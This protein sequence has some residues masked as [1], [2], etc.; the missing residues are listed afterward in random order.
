MSCGNLLEPADT[1]LVYMTQRVDSVRLRLV[2]RDSHVV[3]VPPE[4]ALVVLE[5]CSDLGEQGANVG[6]LVATLLVSV[7]DRLVGLGG[8][9]RETVEGEDEL[10]GEGGDVARQLGKGLKTGKGG[11]RRRGS[12]SSTF[13]PTRPC[14]IG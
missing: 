6:V 5:L 1:L 7:L 12:V 9:G 14:P 10:L 4:L 11:A 2:S 13:H 8:R 3:L